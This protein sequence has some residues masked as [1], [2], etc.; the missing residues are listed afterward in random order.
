MEARGLSFSV[1][2]NDDGV[3]LKVKFPIHVAAKTFHFIE[4]VAEISEEIQHVN[5]LIEQDP[6]TGYFLLV[7]P[8]FPEGD[9]PGFSVNT[10]HAYDPAQTAAIDD[11]F[12]FHDPGMIAVVKAKH[13]L[14]IALFVFSDRHDIGDITAR[15]VFTKD[16]FFCFE[17]FDANFRRITVGSAN[18]YQINVFLEEGRNGAKTRH[19]FN[20]AATALIDL[21]D[22][23]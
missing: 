3:I 22:T 17:T 2:Q 10:A 8:G 11:D 19:I 13:D 23:C 16:K 20:E 1:T 6:A 4:I 14:Q 5:A 15:G 21:T 18:K 9:P 7:A 12:R